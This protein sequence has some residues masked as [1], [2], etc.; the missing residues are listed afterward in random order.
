MSITRADIRTQAKLVAQ[1]P[2]G[3]G[4]GLLVSDPESYNE[5]IDQAKRLFSQ[6]KPNLRIVEQTIATSGWRQTLAGTGAWSGLT[7]LDAWAQPAYIRRLFHPWDAA[8][9]GLAP[10]DPNT[11]RVVQDPGTKFILEFL[12][13]SPQAGD[14]VRIEFSRPHTVADT[15]N[16]TS[17]LACDQDAFIVLTAALILQMA[18]IRAAQNTGNT[19]LPNDVVDRRSQSDIFRSRAKELMGTYQTIVGKPGADGAS[20]A[21]PASG[22]KDLDQPIFSP[23]GPLW[24]SAARR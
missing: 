3:A 24:H 20:T 14:K 11:Y 17:I 10:L 15:T 12:A 22:F 23:V 6:D 4:V 21:P 2:G 7:G 8:S 5:A 19:G 16:G 13:Q 1:D 9:Q 18:A